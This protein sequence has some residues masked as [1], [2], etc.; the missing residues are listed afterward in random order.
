MDKKRAG[1][2][3]QAHGWFSRQPPDF[4]RELMNR[5]VLRHFEEG[6]T[7]Y[8]AGDPAAGVFG[9][10][11]GIVKIEFAVAG[12]T[13]CIASVRQPGYWTGEA[14]AFRLGSRLATN[15]IASPSYILHLPLAEFEH[16]I[17]NPVHCR[18]FATLT[19]EHL[20]EAITVLA[21]M[22]AGTIETRIAAR[23]VMLAQVN[24][25]V[26]SA[27]LTITQGD[28][29]EMCALSRQTVQQLLRSLEMRG[30]ITMRYR[31]IIIP[32]VE[33]LAAAAGSAN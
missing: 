13:Y 23:L 33:S 24:G 20:E 22:M 29:A 32:D 18:C 4:Q 28:L 12:A 21:N 15:K 17:A 8:H 2:I 3:M 19:V 6:E 30:L 26:K 11:E 9:L 5:S 27:D 10:V 25:F 14:A 16:M 31:R 7:L 1:Q